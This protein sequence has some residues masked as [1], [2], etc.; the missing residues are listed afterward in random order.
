[1]IRTVHIARYVLAEAGMLH[2]NAAVHISDPGRITRLEPW[3][4][5]PPNL[6]TKVIDWGS[7]IILPGLVNAHS[8]LELSR[9]KRRAGGPGTFTVWLQDLIGK[10]RKWSREDF[11]ESVREGALLSLS[12]GTTLV[13]DI[14]TAG[15]SGEALKTEKLRKVVFEEVLSFAPDQADDCL[16]G[17]R[18]RLQRTE[19][20]SLLNSGVSPHAPYSVSP[21]LYREVAELARAMGLRLATHVAESREELEF[22]ARGTGDLRS[23]L[24]GLDAW[25]A[26]WVAPGMPPVPYLDGLGCLEQPAILVHCNYLDEDSMALVLSRSCSIVYCPRSHAFFGHDPHPVRRLLD[27]GINVAIGTDSLASNDSLSI[28][29]EMRFLFRTR[30]DLKCDEIL[31]MAT[32]NGAVA[33]DFGNVLGRL[34]RGCWADMTILRL[35]DGINDRH[36][37]SQVLEGAGECLA[38]V[39][40]GEIVWSSLPVP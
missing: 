16:A 9:W 5:P 21:R 10:R 32:L 17:L 36:V 34:R 4:S 37:L 25:Q 2:R 7:A 14:S 27:M 28:L 11:L 35:P 12:A 6:Q 22:L 3:Q 20:D 33:L 26:G 31:R 15:V 19:C 23:F 13:G 39:V 30:K 8:H 38:T 40:Q 24:T 29:D 1:M 18:R